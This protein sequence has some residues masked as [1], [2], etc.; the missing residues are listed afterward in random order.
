VCRACGQ[1]HHYQRCYYL[2]TEKAPPWFH[3]RSEVRQSVNQVLKDD[4][5]LAEEV[6]RLKKKMEKKSDKNPQDDCLVRGV[7]RCEG[8]F[9]TRE[10]TFSIAQYPLKNS[11]ILDSGTTIHI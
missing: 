6:K 8:T 2:F 1:I 5:T 9:L 10:P 4:P 11:A 3:E 7:G